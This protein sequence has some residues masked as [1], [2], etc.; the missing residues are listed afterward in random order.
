[1]CVR[2]KQKR[3]QNQPG[4]LKQRIRGE[5]PERSLFALPT[6]LYFGPDPSVWYFLE[7]IVHFYPCPF[8]TLRR[9]IFVAAEASGSQKYPR[10]AT[11][12]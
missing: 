10:Q 12:G 1:M 3:E 8:Y 9:G 2:R 7:P 4:G 6:R 11:N 5:D